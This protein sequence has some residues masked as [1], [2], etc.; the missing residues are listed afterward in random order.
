[1]LIYEEGGFFLPH[2]DTEKTPGM[3]G[4]LVLVLP[5]FHEGGE[6]VVRHAGHQASL[7]LSGT[8]V[9]EIKFAAFYQDRKV[10]GASVHSC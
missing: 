8:E 3:F 1:M 4:T 7:D 2:R 5:S 6:L 9:S 10:V